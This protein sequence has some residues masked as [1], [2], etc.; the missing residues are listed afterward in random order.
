[1]GD[2]QLCASPKPLKYRSNNA[3]RGFREGISPLRGR[4]HLRSAKRRT[5]LGQPIIKIPVWR[6]FN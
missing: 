3:P 1:L 6:A 5:S 4:T 2:P